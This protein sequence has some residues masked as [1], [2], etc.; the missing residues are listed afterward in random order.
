MKRLGI[1]IYQQYTF[2]NNAQKPHK[3][4]VI[5]VIFGDMQKGLPMVL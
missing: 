1:G 4:I 5:F 2:G 3:Q